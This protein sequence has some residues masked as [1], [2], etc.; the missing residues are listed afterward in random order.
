VAENIHAANERVLIDSVI[1][2]ASV[3]ALFLAR[4][5]GIRE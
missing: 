1:G 3:Y 5:C 2:T 4:W